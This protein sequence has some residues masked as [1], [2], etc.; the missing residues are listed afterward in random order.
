VKILG[1]GITQSSVV[2][3][4]VFGRDVEGTVKK[5]S[6]AK[7]AVFTCPIDLAKT[8]TKGT[9]VFNNAEEMKAFSLGEESQMES[10]VQAIAKMGVNVVVAGSSL[11][12][13]AL[14]YCEKYHI[15]VVRIQSKWEVRRL[16]KAVNATPLVRLGAPIAEEIGHCDL[17]YTDEI[18]SN[19]VTIFRQE[20]DE[21]SIA[22]IVVRA[23]TK[24]LADD[25]ER[26]ID[27]G[28]N[29]VKTLCR[30]ARLL[31]G[32]GATEMELAR[33]ITAHGLTHT[34]L[35]QYAIQQFAISFEAFPRILA[36]SAGFKAT[37]AVADLYAAH[38]KGNVAAGVDIED[39]TTTLDA[40]SAAVMD[41]AATKIAALRHAVE[42]ATT[43]LRIDQIIMARAAGGPKPPKQSQGMDQDDT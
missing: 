25:I 37:E 27:D 43:I 14:H 5:A 12:D 11:A 15:M 39:S 36:E 31:P 33:R 3:G 26:A 28:V 18:G 16:C 13:L 42:A 29:C 4:M 20:A 41:I 7:V 32:A 38:E 10:I 2:K 1:S 17:V 8:E 34:G 19:P 35:N 23:S 9:V 22:T 40:V 21:S 30:D 6:N 24:N